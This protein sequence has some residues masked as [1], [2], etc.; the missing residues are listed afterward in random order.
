MAEKEILEHAVAGKTKE[1]QLVA[2][3]PL[4]IHSSSIKTIKAVPNDSSFY[5]LED[6]SKEVAIYSTDLRVVYEFPT[7]KKNILD[8]KS[9]VIALDYDW[10]LD[11]LGF[12]ATDRQLYLYETKTRQR[13]LHIEEGLPLVGTGIYYLENADIWITT[14]ND[15]TLTVWKITRKVYCTVE[16]DNRH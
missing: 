2:I 3:C 11:I 10:K 13:L 7:V 5:C 6:K 4:K 16:V 15:F 12:L 14:A 9:T 8:K 1:F